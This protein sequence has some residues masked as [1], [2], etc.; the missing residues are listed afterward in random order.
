MKRTIL[1][2]AVLAVLVL[3]VSTVFAAGGTKVCLP[4]KEG[5]PIVTPKSGVCKPGYTLTEFGAEGKEGPAGKEGKEGPKGEKGIQGEKGLSGLAA[6]VTSGGS[7]ANGKITVS[8]SGTG[9]YAVH[10][11]AGAFPTCATAAEVPDTVV[12]PV[13]EG[14]AVMAD[15]VSKCEFNEP[16]Y[17]VTIFSNGGV[18][19]DNGFSLIS[20]QHT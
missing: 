6:A 10:W 18:K 13:Y 1:G 14:I 2:V 3:T 7:V 8:K 16:A 15:V 12:T 17:A 9:E 5:K 19:T 4:G 11:E 20:L